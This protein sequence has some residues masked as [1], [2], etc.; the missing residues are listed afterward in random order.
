MPKGYCSFCGFA[1]ASCRGECE[2]SR[3]WKAYGA[4]VFKLLRQCRP[5]RKPALNPWVARRKDRMPIIGSRFFRW[6]F[7]SANLDH[8]HDRAIFRQK[9]AL[10]VR[11][12][13]R[14]VNIGFQPLD[15]VGFTHN[16]DLPGHRWV[17]PMPTFDDA[18]DSWDDA[19]YLG[20]SWE[21]FMDEAGQDP[22][23]PLGGAWAR[24]ERMSGTEARYGRIR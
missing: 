14:D 3:A 12:E 7:G 2:P 20:A 1:G 22:F 6:W 10:T 23:T 24:T 4:P 17:E 18:Q 19:V 11:G 15:E 8:R 13:G 9:A 16:P 21:N 5:R